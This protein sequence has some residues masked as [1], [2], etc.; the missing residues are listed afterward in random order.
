MAVFD[1]LS[2]PPE[3]LR[4][5]SYAINNRYFTV[6]TADNDAVHDWVDFN[7]RI[8][9]YAV[10]G[11]HVAGF[12]NVMPLTTEAGELFL[13]NE[14]VEE[15]L[16]TEHMLPHEALPFARYAYVAAI[17]IYDT[18]SYRYRQSAAALLATMADLLLDGYSREHFQMLFLNPT[19]FQGNKL[20]TRLGIKPLDAQKKL[21]KPNDIYAVEMNDETRANLV[22]LSNRYARFVGKNPW[23]TRPRDE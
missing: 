17:A 5:Q 11:D 14:I 21:L 8:V 2:P 13:R 10:Q 3:H 6:D 15:D 1:M 7:R 4:A 16:T 23:R 19:T 20:T 18:R 22:Y 9:T 12:F